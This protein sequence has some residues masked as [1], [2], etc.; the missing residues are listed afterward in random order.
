[1]K[2]NKDF[3]DLVYWLFMSSVVVFLGKAFIELMQ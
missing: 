1:M 2:K 3:E